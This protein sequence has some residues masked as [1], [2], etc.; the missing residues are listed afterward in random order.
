MPLTRIARMLREN[1]S[2]SLASV[3]GAASQELIS[4][5]IRVM[6][7]HENAY[8][9]LATMPRLSSLL[10]LMLRASTSYSDR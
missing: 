7:H 3:A 2:G 5:E 1:V 10:A 8:T 4:R 6:G 9:L